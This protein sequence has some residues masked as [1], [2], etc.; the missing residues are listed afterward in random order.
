MSKGDGR[1]MVAS[2][3]ELR[4]GEFSALYTLRRAAPGPGDCINMTCFQEVRYLA[5]ASQARVNRPEVSRDRTVKRQFRYSA[6]SDANASK[7][8]SARLL[9]VTLSSTSPRSCLPR[10]AKALRSDSDSPTLVAAR[11][12]MG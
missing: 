10:L 7:A 6:S 5:G 3:P 12:S 11:N 8:A 1:T 2:S 4:F 9:I